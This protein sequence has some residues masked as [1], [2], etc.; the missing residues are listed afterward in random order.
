MHIICSWCRREGQI[1][2]VGEKEPL[3]DRRETHGIC[4][5]H[6]ETA[7]REWRTVYQDS[8]KEALSPDPIGVDAHGVVID[9]RA[10]FS[11]S[12]D[13]WWNRFKHLVR[14]AAGF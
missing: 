4:L 5:E 12:H 7:S 2:L 6:F 8:A 11:I 10:R 13:R 9:A 3:E 14:K 1:G